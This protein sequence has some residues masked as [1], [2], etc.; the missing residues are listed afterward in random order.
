MHTLANDG[1]TGTPL[2]TE[3]LRPRRSLDQMLQ[4]RTLS[5][6]ETLDDRFHAKGMAGKRKL[7]ETSNGT[8]R[9]LA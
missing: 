2:G 7:P 9:E 5:R 3:K 8:H 6:E 1:G 4:E